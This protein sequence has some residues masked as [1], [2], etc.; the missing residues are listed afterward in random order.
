MQA[1]T[2]SVVIAVALLGG[3]VDGAPPVEPDD[4][5]FAAMAGPTGTHPVT[6][7]ERGSAWE[8]L[9]REPTA[10][11]TWATGVAPFG[12]GEPS[13]T[14]EVGDGTAYFRRV[15]DVPDGV[16]ALLLRVMYDDGFVVYLNGKE[17]GRGSM[18]SGPVTHRTLAFDHEAD[19]RFVEY[20]LSAQLARLE[21]GARNTIVF[22]VHPSRPGSRDLM[23][24]AQLIAWVDG[25]VDDTSHD[26]IERGSIWHY[27][28]R[29]DVAAAWTS[30]GFD[31]AGWSSGPG[32]LG[33]GEAFVVTPTN[34][35]TITT[36]FRKRFTHHGEARG[37]IADVRYDDG[38]IAYL[39][40]KEIAR[41][42]MARGVVTASTRARAHEAGDPERLDWSAATPLLVD[43]VNVL[44]IEVH[45][46]AM[47]SADLVLDLELTME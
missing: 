41:A 43:G 24:D 47:S 11:A 30:P 5:V 16:R 38:F 26:G 46:S 17:S 21:P 7:I 34:P 40:G 27:W 19:R 23:F 2:A 45:Q 37:L 18:P 36:Y 20:D 6:L 25:P 22:Q 29:P 28:D 10:D 12:R 42:G 4:A 35:G 1:V 8:Y 31:D 15:V 33:R 44:A 9:D 3:C 14:T 32:P 39:N 13:V